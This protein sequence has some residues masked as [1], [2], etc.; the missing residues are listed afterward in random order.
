MYIITRF[1]FILSSELCEENT[2]NKQRSKPQIHHCW[3]M[4][5]YP[6]E[7]ALPLYVLL[8]P[9]FETTDEIKD[10]LTETID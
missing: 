8:S 2:S 7:Q 10:S 5:Y 1:K 6:A 3:R 9:V 4:F